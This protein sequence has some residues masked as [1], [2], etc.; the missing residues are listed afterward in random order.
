[1]A[2]AR[3]LDD[4]LVE[5]ANLRGYFGALGGSAVN[6]THTPELTDEALIV[7]VLMPHT[8]PADLCPKGCTPALKTFNGLASGATDPRV[9]SR[10]ELR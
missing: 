3:A 4:W 2:G 1:M 9:A 6:R 10:D 7:A 5:E 8:P